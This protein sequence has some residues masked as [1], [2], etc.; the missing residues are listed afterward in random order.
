M[1]LPLSSE[2]TI[3]PVVSV[4]ATDLTY[5]TVLYILPNH[6]FVNVTVPLLAQ[7]WNDWLVEVGCTMYE[8]SEIHFLLMH[9]VVAIADA[10]P[11]IAKEA[12]QQRITV[13]LHLLYGLNDC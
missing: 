13:V 1:Y 12:E 5:S 4:L 6:C 3:E 11:A 7:W 2:S 10:H 8:S 9:A